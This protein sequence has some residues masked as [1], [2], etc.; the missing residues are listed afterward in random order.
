MIRG[1]KTVKEKE[2]NTHSTI[3]DTYYYVLRIFVT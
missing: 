2:T 3:V 1:R